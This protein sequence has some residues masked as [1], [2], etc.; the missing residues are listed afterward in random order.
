MTTPGYTRRGSDDFDYGATRDNQG[1]EETEA[2]E[3]GGRRRKIA[4]YLKAAN[5]LRQSYQT[6]ANAKWEARGKEE[7]E[8]KEAMPGSFPDVSI[9]RHGNEE[10]ILFPS[11]CKRHVKR[12]PNSELAPDDL[13]RT[14]SGDS[15]DSGLEWWKGEWEKY[16]DDKAIVDVDVRGWVYTPH[17]G[18]LNRK[19]RLLLGIARRLSGVPAPK[20]PNSREGSPERTSLKARHE[21][22]EAQ[23]DEERITREAE[24]IMRKGEDET[25]VAAR[26]DY[27]EGRGQGPHADRKPDSRSRSRGGNDEINSGQP[28]GSGHISKRSTWN[29]PADMS[30]EELKAA[31]TNLMTRIMPFLTN[32]LVST[33]ITVFFYDSKS[34]QSKTV[35]TNESGHFDLRAALDFVPTHIRVLASENLSATEEVKITEPKGVSMISDVDD[36]VKHSSISSGARVI[37][38]NA[39]IRDLG[40]LTI[41]GVKEWYNQMY[42]MGVGIHYV[43]NSPWQLFPVLATFFQ[44][45]GLPPGS[46]HLK[47]YSGMLQGIFEPVAERK[48]GTLERI[49]RDFPERKFLLVGDSG[50]AD[51]EVYMDVVLANPG[52]I[53]GVFIRDVTTPIEQPFFDESYNA[54]YV[55]RRLTE[56]PV[57]QGQSGGNTRTT[58]SDESDRPDN[59]PPLPARATSGTGPRMGD[60]IDFGDEP[61][62]AYKPSNND[63]SHFNA[64]L[65]ELELPSIRSKSVPEKG[66]KAPPPPPRPSKPLSLRSRTI[67]FENASHDSHVG[68]RPAELSHQTHQ[69]TSKPNNP[70][71]DEEKQKQQ[72]AHDDDSYFSAASAKAADAYNSMPSVSSYIP[73]SSDLSSPDSLNSSSENLSTRRALTAK[74]AS[75]AASAS[76]RISAYRSSRPDVPSSLKR[77][78]SSDSDLSSGASTPQIN[79]KLELW[80]RRWA[81]ATEILGREG[82]TLVKWRTG[83][84]VADQATQ[85]VKKAMKEMGV[86]GHN[87]ADG[88]GKTGKGGGEA[89]VV[90]LKK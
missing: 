69:R 3:R 58:K 21:A 25:E 18:P 17:R 79:K 54:S 8:D 68:N 31:N 19:N 41:D 5:E 30:P 16:E 22:R 34:S 20:T 35:T 73:F 61:N 2:P 45:A 23:R 47:Q 6:A 49:L 40:D 83:V 85:L 66:A 55:S 89:K 11:Y 62:E 60:L 82:V 29:Q 51:L 86:E 81:R 52:R 38:R 57:N 33:P 46:Y 7:D 39:F 78:D 74:A 26:G 71:P 77:P 14:R 70:L 9:V 59:R 15:T 64:D 84:D 27:S 80:N 67:S 65:A 32:P 76:N 87:G 13:T 63:P 53:I 90:D 56:K 44:T 48:K 43:S 75:Y 4:G 50:E 10:L 28:L 72:P 24:E 42:D 36:T 1:N 37:F 88:K 12:R